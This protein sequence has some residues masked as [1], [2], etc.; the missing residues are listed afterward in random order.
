MPAGWKD[1]CEKSERGF[2]RGAWRERKGIKV[3][4]GNPQILSLS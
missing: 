1:V 4:E 3:G 2:V